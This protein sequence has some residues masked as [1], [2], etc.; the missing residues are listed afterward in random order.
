MRK[1]IIKYGSQEDIDKI[2]ELATK[3][4]LYIF[5]SNGVL[6]KNYFIRNENKINIGKVTRKNIVI[7]ENYLNEWSSNYRIILTDKNFD[8]S[9]EEDFEKIII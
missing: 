3:L 9:S 5:I 1:N 7:K 4:N 2:I 6:L 8:F